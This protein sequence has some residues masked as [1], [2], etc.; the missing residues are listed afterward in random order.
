MADYGLDPRRVDP[1]Y[2]RHGGFP[3]FQAAEPGPGFGRFLAAM[4]RLQDLAVS[5]DPGPDVWVDAADRV[6]G[7]VTLL[8][9]YQAPE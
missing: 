6:E 1:E 3:V 7:L 5:A 4:R 8:D 9:P 2:D